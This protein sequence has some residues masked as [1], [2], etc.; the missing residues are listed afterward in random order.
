MYLKYSNILIATVLLL[1]SCEKKTDCPNSM[2]LTVSNP[3]P[4][5]GESFEITAPALDGNGYF[6]WTG[7][8]NFSGTIGNKLTISNAKYAGR[9][10][11]YCA[12]TVTDCNK[13]LRDSIF[14]DVK[15]K[16]NAPPCSPTNN[17]ITF[18][19][20]PNLTVTSVTYGIDP[21]YNG[22][23]LMGSGAFGYPSSFRVLFNSY[24]GV[25]D[26]PDGVYNTTSVPVF[27]VTQDFEDVSV[28]F[29]YNSNYFHSQPGQKIYVS[30][31]GGKVSVKMCSLIFSQVGSGLTTQC[32]GQITRP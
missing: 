27:D 23:A 12:K 14:V 29:I 31:V 19:S 1:S 32:T 8:G 30:H 9:G 28:S 21:T 3:T 20:I 7:P 18:S 24:N 10:W 15:L 17:L 22:M 4:T 6:T 16:Q 25:F 13:T 2:R 11:Y 26:P 5:V